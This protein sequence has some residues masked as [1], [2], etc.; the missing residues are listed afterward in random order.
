MRNPI[1]TR[2]YFVDCLKNGKWVNGDI[3]TSTLKDAEEIAKHMLGKNGVTQTRIVS[4]KE[5]GD[6]QIHRNYSHDDFVKNPVK[7]KKRLPE[8]HK[9]YVLK[10]FNENMYFTGN[11]FST[12]I[13]NAAIWHS[14]STAKKIGE[15]IAKAHKV[16][17]SLMVM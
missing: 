9:N 6:R 10:I 7:N 15:V 13:S 1:K 5:N 3:P 4:Y 12:L 8:K 14:E 17:I 2:Q 16:P 11:G